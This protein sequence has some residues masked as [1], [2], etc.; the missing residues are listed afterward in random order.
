MKNVTQ[1]ISKFTN[2]WVT[3]VRVCQSV[4]LLFVKIIFSE[5]KKYFQIILY[6]RTQTLIVRSL[7]E[8]IIDFCERRDIDFNRKTDDFKDRFKNCPATSFIF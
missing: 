3:T 5:L 6:R 2:F 1:N 8:A 7:Y 4:F